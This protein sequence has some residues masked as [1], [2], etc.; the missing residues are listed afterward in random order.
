MDTV[1]SDKGT[2]RKHA[3]LVVEDNPSMRLL[4][5]HLLQVAYEVEA[6][7]GIDEA[8]HRAE[9]QVFD[10]LVLDIQL[11]EDRTGVDLLH[12]LRARPAYREVPALA[13]TAYA[14]SGDDFL[15]QGFDAFL[16]KPFSREALYAVL[17]RIIGYHEQ[18]CGNVALGQIIRQKPR[19]PAFFAR[20]LA[21]R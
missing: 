11:G 6:V 7:S 2:N 1:T 4:F 3:L 5:K 10:G 8:L 16:G 18:P 14:Q 13:C 9:Q 20:I 19:I 21:F 15:K 12:I 17:E